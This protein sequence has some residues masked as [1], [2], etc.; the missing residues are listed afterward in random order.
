MTRRRR[1]RWILIVVTIGLV[2]VVGALFGRG[3][4]RSLGFGASSS[5]AADAD[6]SVV[7]RGD[8]VETVAVAGELESEVS[9][10][11]G[12]P[13]VEETWEFKISWLA[14]EGARVEVGEPVL[15]FD[16]SELETKLA[17]KMAERDAALQELA[18]KRSE[19][20]LDRG[21]GEL[22]LAEAEA[23]RRRAA[24]RADVP[25]ELASRLELEEAKRDLA[26]GQLEE[27]FRREELSQSARADSAELAA[28]ADARDRAAARVREMAAAVESMTVRAPVAGTVVYIANRQGQKRRVGDSCWR[29]DRVVEIPDLQ[30]MRAVGEIEEVDIGRA[31]VGQ[32]VRFSLDAQ[33]DVA[34][35]GR[36]AALGRAVRKPPNGGPTG[37]VEAVISIERID[38]LRMRPG[39]RFR[40]EV[41][42]ARTKEVV[43]VPVEAVF[44]GPLGPRVLRRTMFGFAP[45]RPDL[46]RHNGRYFEVRSGL[47]VG[48][49]V[50]LR[51]LAAE[52]AR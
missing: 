51:D 20:A 34:F 21:D 11:L 41:E 29:M 24:L 43:L 48:D 23:R 5:Q 2:S 6:W 30:R 38:P 42:I 10:A 47:S 12:P 37:V 49:R 36:L 1:L 17:E 31:A 32:S 50:A 3:V 19:L 28:L 8:L 4:G 33:P 46:G 26:L 52:S 44:P 15:R 35:L 22:L 40:G 25:L 16:A 7:E 18:K 14:P 45:L 39:M 9:A 27:K 13:Q